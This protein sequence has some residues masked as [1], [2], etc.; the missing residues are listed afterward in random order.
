MFWGFIR[1]EKVKI[2]ENMDE[3]DFRKN[4]SFKLSAYS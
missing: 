3:K 4:L 1:I 2:E